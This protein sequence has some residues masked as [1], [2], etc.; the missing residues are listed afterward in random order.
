[1]SKTNKI[2]ECNYL[3]GKIAIIIA[4]NCNYVTKLCKKAITF[5]KKKTV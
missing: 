1:M 3:K 5:K 4:F 2:Q